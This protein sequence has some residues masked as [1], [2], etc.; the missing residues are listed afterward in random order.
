M[1]LC[2]C[3]GQVQQGQLTKGRESWSCKVCGRY[4]ILTTEESADVREEKKKPKQ[5]RPDHP[6]TD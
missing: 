5:S 4:E 3:G 2:Q 6:V 1:R